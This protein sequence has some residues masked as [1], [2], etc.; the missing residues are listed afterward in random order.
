[1]TI[2]STQNK[3]LHSFFTTTYILWKLENYLSVTH[4]SGGVFRN[5]LCQD[6]N[7]LVIFLRNYYHNKRIKRN[8]T[9]VQACETCVFTYNI[10]KLICANQT[11][12][13]LKEKTS[14]NQ[15]FV[16]IIQLERLK[17]KLHGLVTDET[18]VSLQRETIEG[19][20]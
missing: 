18:S 17:K 3:L 5:T 1:M 10:C 2:I 4:F 11:Y 13:L 6:G 15:P 19:N 9:G 12:N 20:H 14:I 7:I 16:M 8:T